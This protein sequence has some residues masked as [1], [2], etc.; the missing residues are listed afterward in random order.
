MKSSIYPCLWFDG[1]AEEAAKLYCS[2]FSDSGIDVSTPLVCTFHIKNKQFMGLNGG[3]VFRP[4]PSISFFTVC[5]TEEEIN[6]AWELLV[7]GGNVMMPLDSYAWSNK[8]GFV[9][10][11]YGVSWQLSLGNEEIQDIFPS[12]MFVGEQNGNAEKAISFYTSL[13]QHSAVELVA[14]YDS[15]DHDIEGN[16]K[17]SQFHLDG[18]RMSAMDSSIPDNFGFNQGI[19]LVISCDTQEEIDF[20]W[21]NLAEGGIEDRCGWCQDSFGVWWQVVPSILSSLM[22]D[23]AKAPK[24][25]DA[26]MKMKKFDIAELEKAAQQN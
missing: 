11:K 10:D 16:V 3:A 15:G 7:E 19:S 13:F 24:V 9:Q 17:Y 18:Y 23:P 25:T 21:L 2:A 14:K 4:N 22:K 8:Y 26:F 5:K 6:H 12:L 20:Y 1:N